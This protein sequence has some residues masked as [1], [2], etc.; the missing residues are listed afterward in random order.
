MDPESGPLLL[1]QRLP[2]VPTN[3]ISNPF[4]DLNNGFMIAEILSRYNPDMVSMHSYENSNNTDFKKSN[5]F[6]LTKTFKKLEIVFQKEEY[7]DIKNGNFDLLV[8]FMV[9]LYQKLTKR[10]YTNSGLTF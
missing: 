10:R 4:R 2:K 8:E 6:M 3:P 1:L 5:W 9:K 7:D